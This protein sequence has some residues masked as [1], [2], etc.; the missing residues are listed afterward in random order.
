MKFRTFITGLVAIAGTLL[1]AGGLVFWQL[2]ANSPTTLLTRG[3]QATPLAAQ[4]IPRQAP[5]MVSLLARPDRLWSLRQV[6]TDPDQ[7]F[8]TRRDWQTLTQ[9][10][11]QLSGLDY[12]Q[13]LRPW[14]GSEVTF[15]VTAADLDKSPSN[16]QQPGYLLVL[17]SRKGL[18]AR[19][20]LHLFWQQRGLAGEE[21][22]FEPLSGLTLIYNR[23]MAAVGQPPDTFQSL[24]STVVGDRYILIANS[25]QV[26]RQAIATYRAPDVSLAREAA[27]RDLLATLPPERIGWMYGNLP[28][29]LDWLGLRSSPNALDV[30]ASGTDLQK[31]FLSWRITRQGLI[32]DT[33]LTPVPGSQFTQPPESGPKNPLSALRWLPPETTLALGGSDLPTLWQTALDSVGGYGLTTT[34]KPLADT[35]TLGQADTGPAA[36]PALWTQT[37]RPYALGWLAPQNDWIFV[38]EQPTSEANA[39]AQLDALAQAQGWGVARL[40]LDQQPITAWTRL[41]VAATPGS[42]ALQL[43]TQVMAVHTHRAGF[44]IFATSLSALQQ[45]LETPQVQSLEP[46]LAEDTTALPPGT[47]V[48]DVAYIQWPQLRPYLLTRWPGLALVA[49]VA[50][51]LTRDFGVFKIIRRQGMPQRQ[52]AQ[53]EI[54]WARP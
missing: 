16:G 31:F 35:L 49:Q 25:P 22:I 4:F 5:L 29:T 36:L 41:S 52:Q 13:D 28:H 45:A 47:P 27:Y 12:D 15:A 26:L 11:K 40:T 43:N 18:E 17:T 23:P 14:L 51:P 30:S 19:E 10:L 39:T 46:L 24:A 3:G 2:T 1:L 50:Q 53:L 54:A 9:G 8:Q 42:E 21:L 7:R 32:A 48:A 37:A 38:T 6:L 34:L 33:A 20:A 44:E